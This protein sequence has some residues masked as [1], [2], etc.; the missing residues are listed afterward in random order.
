MSSVTTNGISS[1][2]D[3][4]TADD[5]VAPVP[6]AHPGF[7]APVVVRR[8]DD[9]GRLVTADETPLLALEVE[10]APDADER[11]VLPLPADRRLV[12]VT[13][14]HAHVRREAHEDVHDRPAHVLERIARAADR[15]GEER[16]A[17][18]A[19]LAVDDEGEPARAVPR[20]AQRLDPQVAG[21]DDGAV[22]RGL[23]AGDALGGIGDDPHA[24]A[25]FELLVLGDVVAVA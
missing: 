21:L 7:S 9:E 13:G 25:P 11:V 4:R 14:V 18:E 24:E 19:G 6:E 10:P 1:P 17:G 5:R 20:R 3:S 22:R 2:F 8:P 16:V 23:G 12:R 15:A